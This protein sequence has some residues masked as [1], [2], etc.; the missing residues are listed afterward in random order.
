MIDATWIEEGILEFVRH[1]RIDM[2]AMGT[3]GYKGLTHFLNGSRAEDVANHAN[4]PVL[5]IKVA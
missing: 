2:I 1:N 5:T 3:H 4:I